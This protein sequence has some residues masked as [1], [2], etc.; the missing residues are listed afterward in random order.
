MCSKQSHHWLK[1]AFNILLSEHT[2][3]CGRW[4]QFR[5]KIKAGPLKGPVNRHKATTAQ[6]SSNK[7]T[8][9]SSIWHGLLHKTSKNKRIHKTFTQKEFPFEFTS[10][11]LSHQRSGSL[12]V[13]PQKPF[14]SVAML[15]GLATRVAIKA[16]V[17]EAHFNS[18]FIWVSNN[19]KKKAYMEYIYKYGLVNEWLN[20]RSITMIKKTHRCF[21]QVVW[22][23]AAGRGYKATRWGSRIGR[24]SS[25]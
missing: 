17:W 1:D 5:P 14:R 4:L 20:R 25:H 22:K 13:A 18:L 7:K 15:Q 23:G 21:T 8:E 9:Y 2:E 11:A 24:M 19:E 10:R 12:I 3:S 6:T 16:S